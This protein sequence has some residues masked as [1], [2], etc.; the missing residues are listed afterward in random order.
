MKCLIITPWCDDLVLN[1]VK[2]TPENA[3]LYRE[4][5]KRGVE[6]QVLC[7]D[8]R[9]LKPLKEG[10]LSFLYEGMY[11]RQIMDAIRKR[12]F[13]F[14]ISITGLGAKALKK[15]GKPFFVK[16]LGAF[17]YWL[18]SKIR[19]ALFHR[20]FYRSL[21]ASPRRVVMTDDGTD[22]ERAIRD[23]GYKKEVL[24][25]K[26]GY[27]KELLNLEKSDSDKIRVGF[28]ASLEKIKGVDYLISIIKNLKEKNH[29]KFIIAGAGSFKEK[30]LKLEKENPERVEY[31]GYLRYLDMPNFY[32]DVDI[33]LSLNRYANGTLPVVEAQAAGIPV[34]AFDIQKTSDFIK[35][36]VSGFLVEPFHLESIEFLLRTIKKKQL[37]GMKKNIQEFAKKNFMNTEERA[38]REVEFYMEA[39]SE[40]Y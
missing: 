7:P 10:R 30:I 18:V 32:R 34:V 19:R 40:G 9:S 17:D 38:V 15:T 28:A 26:N 11:D 6:I 22:G 1:T 27:F 37:L 13:N 25:L 3:Y 29:L 5:S 35:N 21:K 4:L 16:Y 14:A 20:R 12:D 39:L 23:A 2:G 36:N 24:F 31:R 33:L 8:G